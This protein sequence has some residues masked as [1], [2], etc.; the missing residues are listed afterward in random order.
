[1]ATCGT[2]KRSGRVTG[3]VTGTVPGRAEE[4]G[5]RAIESPGERVGELLRWK[6]GALF[7]SDVGDAMWATLGVDVRGLGVEV[8]IGEGDVLA[9]EDS[10]EHVRRNSAAA[11]ERLCGRKR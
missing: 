10:P 9:V 7:A 3:R 11:K 4:D 2:A 5:D 8:V 6:A 1:M